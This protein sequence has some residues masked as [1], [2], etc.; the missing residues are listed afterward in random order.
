M[1]GLNA[2]SGIGGVRT[3]AERAMKYA[4]ARVLMPCRALE[5][6][7]PRVTVCVKN[8]NAL[9]VLM[10]CRALEAFG[11]S[12]HT[13]AAYAAD[14]AVLMPCRALEA[15]GRSTGL[16]LGE[17]KARLRLNALSGI[18]GVRTASSVSRV[19]RCRLRLNA[20][21]GIG[22][23]RTRARASTSISGRSPS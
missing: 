17:D 7:G 2:L 9:Y 13:V 21:S 5:A 18:G 4:C 19:N 16:G 14:L 22:G 20:L 1:M 3:T 8:E 10:P 12:P 6:F 23:V 11:R 15:F